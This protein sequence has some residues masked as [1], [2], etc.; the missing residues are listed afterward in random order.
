MD[1]LDQID[2]IK[3]CT[4]YKYKDRILTEFPA[5]LDVLE[6]CEPVFDVLPGWKTSTREN[7]RFE[8]LP[9]NAQKYIQ[10]IEQKT[11]IPVNLISVGAKRARTILC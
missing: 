1:V 4:G 9:L 7:T 2:E 10:Y 6:N 11:G 3:V 8:D 5:D